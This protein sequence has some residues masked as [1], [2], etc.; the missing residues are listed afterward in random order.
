MA[1]NRD[2]YDTAISDYKRIAV[3]AEAEV[4]VPGVLYPPSAVVQGRLRAVEAMKAA[5]HQQCLE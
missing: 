1:V 5:W 4:P 2:D 3:A